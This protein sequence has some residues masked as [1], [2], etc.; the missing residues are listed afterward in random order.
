[1]DVSGNELSGTLPSQIGQLTKLE[2]LYVDGNK[3]IGTM[4]DGICLLRNQRLADLVADCQEVSCKIPCCTV[5][6]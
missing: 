2:L 4:P 3:F 1:L 6:Y 5:C